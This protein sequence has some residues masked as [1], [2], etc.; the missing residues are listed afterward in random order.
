[1]KQKKFNDKRR[2]ISN[3][4]N[5]RTASSAAYKRIKRATKDHQKSNYDNQTDNKENNRN[6]DMSMGLGEEKKLKGKTDQKEE[7]P[8]SSSEAITTPSS[9]LPTLST[10]QPEV[11]DSYRYNAMSETKETAD[12]GPDNSSKVFSQVEEKQQLDPSTISSNDSV[13]KTEPEN[14]L[15]TNPDTTS[16]PMANPTLEERDRN[17]MKLKKEDVV[18]KLDVKQDITQVHEESEK[19]DHLGESVRFYDSENKGSYSNSPNYDNNPFVSVIKL[20]Q[21]Y[22]VAWINGYNEFMK[23]WMGMI[24]S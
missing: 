13:K 1:M 20:W 10:V 12:M 2:N 7:K 3:T 6:I 24:K 5:K 15:N 18:S 11:F 4:R 23:A 9:P 17:V 19:Q 16:F 22:N 8:S 21:S 14:S